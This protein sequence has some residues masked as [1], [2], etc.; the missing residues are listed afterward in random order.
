MAQ[1]LE[2]VLMEFNFSVNVQ[3]YRIRNGSATACTLNASV[4]QRERDGERR[5]GR[6][7][8][9]VCLCVSTCYII[10]RG[11]RECCLACHTTATR[12]IGRR[13]AASELNST[14]QDTR[15][16][17]LKQKYRTK[18]CLYWRAHDGARGRLKVQC[19]LRS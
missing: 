18:S 4:S 2:K 17:A 11:G 15:L 7:G 8:V 3:M 19:L 10:N 5:R 12:C 9:C 6:A 13:D 14:T 16:A 1:S